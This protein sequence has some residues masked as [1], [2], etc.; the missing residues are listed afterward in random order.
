MEIAGR[1]QWKLV[2][3]WLKSFGVSCHGASGKS[4]GY[5]GMDA[6]HMARATS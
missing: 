3:P 2:F 1:M 5:W 6:K 4:K